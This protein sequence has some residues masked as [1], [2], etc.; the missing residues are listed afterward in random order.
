MGVSE[1]EIDCVWCFDVELA[2]VTGYVM[3]RKL[4][5]CLLINVKME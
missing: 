2:D 3:R 1:V 4:V 5:V